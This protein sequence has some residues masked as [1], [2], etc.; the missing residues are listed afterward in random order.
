MVLRPPSAHLAALR[1]FTLVELLVVI[2]IIAVLVAMLLPALNKARFSAY[3]IACLSNVRQLSMG[4]TMYANENQGWLPRYNGTLANHWTTLIFPYVGK[5]TQVFECP[6]TYYLAAPAGGT[7]T[8]SNGSASSARQYTARLSYKVNG[9]DHG[10]NQQTAKYYPFGPIVDQPSGSY[11]VEP[12]GDAR[13]M[14][15]SNVSQDTIMLCDGFTQMGPAAIGGDYSA[16]HFGGPTGNGCPL[17]FGVDS[18]G[19]ASHNGK[20]ASIAFADN[21]CETVAKNTMLIDPKYST[22]SPQIITSVNN[23]GRPGDLQITWN[24]SNQ[25]RGYWTGNKG[26]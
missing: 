14:R 8:L 15:I 24:N 7:L 22:G 2:G 6:L 23:Y 17:Y 25:P 12:V 1:G 11:Y 26:D 4:V 21:H 3:Q 18:I 13:T 10:G 19:L 5:S 16:C 9:A 20:S